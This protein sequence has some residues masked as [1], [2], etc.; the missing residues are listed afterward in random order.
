[1]EIALYGKKIG[2][3]VL[4]LQKN[5]WPYLRPVLI[6]VMIPKKKIILKGSIELAEQ[7]G[8]NFFDERCSLV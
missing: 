5:V 4:P 3:P 7:K 2:F 8:C 6:L 1:L